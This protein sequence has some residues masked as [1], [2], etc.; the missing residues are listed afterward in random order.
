M[1]PKLPIPKILQ[2]LNPD[3]SIYEIRA[4]L[5]IIFNA[6]SNRIRQS[7]IFR[8]R[9]PGIGVIRSRANKRPKRTQA[10]KKRDRERK[11]KKKIAK[12]DKKK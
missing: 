12:T 11:R 1:P 9:I 3:L 6:K 8:I 2:Q 5:N 4:I 7:H 10:V